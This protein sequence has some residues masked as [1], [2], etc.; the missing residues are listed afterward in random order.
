MATGTTPQTPPNEI[1]AVDFAALAREVAMDILP[2]QQIL[3]LHRLTDA[4]WV[5][6]AAHP[7]FIEMLTSMVRDWNAAANT[8]ERVRVKA[9][10]GLESQLEIYIRDIGDTDIP[11]NQRVEAGKFLA[12]LGELDGRGELIGQTVGSGVTININ[13]GNGQKTVSL[14]ANAPVL[15]LEAEDD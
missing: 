12:R 7:K 15:E 3:E 4:E 8:G 14:T 2:L 10:T 9:Q 1:F 6:I 5:R 11:L 13:T